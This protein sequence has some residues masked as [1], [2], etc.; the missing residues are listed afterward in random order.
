MW[1]KFLMTRDTISSL[2]KPRLF[3]TKRMGVLMAE[4]SRLERALPVPGSGLSAG[5][6]LGLCLAG[7]ESGELQGAERDLCVSQSLNGNS[8]LHAHPHACCSVSSDFFCL[9]KKPK[10]PAPNL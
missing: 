4:A 7:G 3:F 9:F 10:P 1:V 5:P 6:A 8:S 2:P